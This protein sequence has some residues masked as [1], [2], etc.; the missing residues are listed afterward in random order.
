MYIV[1]HGQGFWGII[2][3]LLALDYWYIQKNFK[4]PLYLISE[5]IVFK[6]PLISSLA[7]KG[8]LKNAS[9]KNIELL[10][11][12]GASIVIP[13]G[14]DGELLKPFWMKDKPVF[15]K[16]IYLNGKMILKT[17][18][19]FLDSSLKTKTPIVPL[20]ISGTHEM[21][22]II[23]TS[24]FIHK[25]SGMAYWRRNEFLPGY[26]ITINHFINLAI[27]LLT[28]FSDS[29]LA[30][31]IFILA[32]IYI[33]FL[34]TYPIIFRKIYIRFSN[35]ITIPNNLEYEFLDSKKRKKVRKIYL[36]KI[37]ESIYK[38]IKESSKERR[39]FFSKCHNLFSR[40][41]K[42]IFFKKITYR[43]FY[44]IYMKRYSNFNGNDNEYFIK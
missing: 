30:W 40:Y 41:N 43:Y 32:H 13:P 29:I 21:T 25:Y 8:G 33:D 35:K 19:W 42:F 20:S 7:L 16:S 14:G 31:I 36:F 4:T 18:T 6:I 5:E 37:Y 44:K 10:L 27:F 22:P 17:Q 9:R 24:F 38:G 28:P 23:Y 26:P 3:V 11:E 15:T 2:D 1:N 12:T 39:D 34:Y